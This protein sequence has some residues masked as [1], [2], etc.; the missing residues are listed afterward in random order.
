MDFNDLVPVPVIDGDG[1]AA[2]DVP[3]AEIVTQTHLSILDLQ[4]DRITTDSEG[5]TKYF[6]A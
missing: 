5:K 4:D 2:G 6:K 1:T 3:V